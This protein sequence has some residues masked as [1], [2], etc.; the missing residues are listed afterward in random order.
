MYKSVGGNK[1]KF[2][3]FGSRFRFKIFDGVLEVMHCQTKSVFG[4]TGFVEWLV[5][6]SIGF[7]VKNMIWAKIRLE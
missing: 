3:F 4:V 7:K 2:Y 1:S 6:L 5:F